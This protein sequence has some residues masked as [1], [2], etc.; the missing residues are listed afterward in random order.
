MDEQHRELPRSAALP[1]DD[2]VLPFRTVRS[3]VEGRLVRLA[4]VAD[5]VLARHDYP[6]PISRALGEALA[7]T[8]ML[9]SALRLQRRLILEA[10]T[11]GILRAVSVHYEAPGRLRGYAS[12][13]KARLA[14]VPHT[15]SGPLALLG[16]GNLALT[17]E[18]GQGRDTYQ[19][20]VALEGQSLSDA[21]LTYFRQSEQLPTFLRLVVARHFSNDPGARAGGWRWRA[22]GLMIQHLTADGVEELP[23]VE[24]AEHAQWQPGEDEENWRRARFLAETVQ[25]HELLDPT[26]PPERLLYR[27]FHEEGVRVQPAIALTA[28]CRCS[29][30]RIATFL[31]QFGAEEL[32]DLRDPDGGFVV[33]CEF[34]GRTYSFNQL[35]TNEPEANR[36]GP[37]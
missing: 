25:D 32:E 29:R 26:L 12:Y 22:A 30:E 37:K 1:G 23:E 21:A 9:G 34:C 33:T 31:E 6:E 16:A 15:A 18:P 8:A 24:F 5:D 4:T 35:E 13:D 10:R 28:Y 27:L 17:I 36:S 14:D 19:G 3:G 20:I 7:L 11:D 2:A